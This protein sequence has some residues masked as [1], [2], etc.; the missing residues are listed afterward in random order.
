MTCQ[1]LDNI[2][3]M[4]DQRAVFHLVRKHEKENMEMLIFQDQVS[5]TP[6]KIKVKLFRLE[7]DTRL[8]SLML[9]QDQEPMI[10][11]MTLCMNTPLLSV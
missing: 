1:V 8:T 3:I 2:T 4:M 7:L 10:R 5:T 11:K 9:A 6:L